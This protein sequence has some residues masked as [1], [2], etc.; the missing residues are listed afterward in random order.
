[1]LKKDLI[2]EVAQASGHSEKAVREILEATYSRVIQALAS[3]TSVMLLGLGKLSVVRRGEKRARD[4]RTGE[5]VMV[6]PRNV[7]TMRPSD[8]VNEAIN[9]A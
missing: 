1:M 2:K 3:G 8:S 5:V 4:L 6:P 7:V 9:A